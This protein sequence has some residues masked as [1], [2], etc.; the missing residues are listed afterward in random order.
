M[1][2]LRARIVRSWSHSIVIAQTL[3]FRAEHSMRIG[4]TIISGAGLIP[5]PIFIITRKARPAKRRPADLVEEL[6]KRNIEIRGQNPICRTFR[7]SV[8]DT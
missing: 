5:A 1:P 6:G 3:A 7:I 8:A 4:W 2:R